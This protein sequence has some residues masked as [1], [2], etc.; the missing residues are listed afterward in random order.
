MVI[1]KLIIN[2]IYFETIKLSHDIANIDV[3]T[4]IQKRKDNNIARNKIQEIDDVLAAVIYRLKKAQNFS[5]KNAPIIGLLE[6][7]IADFSQD[8]NIVS[9]PKLRIKQD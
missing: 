4:Y 5:G 6:K 7:T 9:S 8:K 2:I 1:T 3:V